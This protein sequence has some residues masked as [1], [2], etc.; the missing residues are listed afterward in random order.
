MHPASYPQS[1]PWATLITCL[2]QYRT[3]MW[4]LPETVHHCRLELPHDEHCC[5]CGIKWRD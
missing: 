5:A 4:P 3:R 1:E 2:A